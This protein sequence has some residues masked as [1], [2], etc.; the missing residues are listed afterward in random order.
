MENKQ[1]G[2]ATLRCVRRRGYYCCADCPERTVCRRACQNRPEVCGLARG[3]APRK[4]EVE[5]FR[6]PKTDKVG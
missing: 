1:R 2:C 4:K 6:K 5:N 3:R